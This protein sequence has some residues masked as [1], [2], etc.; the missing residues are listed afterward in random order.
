M[1]QPI[2]VEIT[3][4]SKGLTAAV[5]QAN[6]SLRKL[7]GESKQASQSLSNIDKGFSNLTKATAAVGGLY[8]VTAGV[9]D[10]TLSLIHI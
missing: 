9:R 1:A 4:D 6:A 10:V 5:G 8:A 3:G 2:R 7:E